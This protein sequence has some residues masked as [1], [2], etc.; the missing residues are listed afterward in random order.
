MKIVAITPDRK[1]NALVPLIIDGLYDN[2]I[3]VIATDPGNGVRSSDVYTDGEVIEHAQDADY[4][5]ALFGK[6]KGPYREGKYHLLDKIKRPEVTAYITDSEWT[7]TSYPDSSFQCQEAKTDPSRHR[8]NPWI[9]EEMYEKCSWYFKRLVFPEDLDRKKIVPCY[10]GA[11]NRYFGPQEEKQYDIFCSF[12][13]LEDGL[14]QP[15]H[16]YCLD[17][18]SQGRNVLINEKFNFDTYLKMIRRSQIGVSA[19][20]AGNCCMRMWEISANKTCCFIQKPFHIVYPNRFVDGESCVYY[21]SMDE[22]KDKM[23][24]YLSRPDECERIGRNAYNHIVKYHTGK[25]RV[26]YMLNV[27]NGHNW[28]TASEFEYNFDKNQ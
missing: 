19:W 26:Q 9:N 8:G 13:Q 22:F 24:F 18:K 1:Y 16:D 14:R 23:Q 12:G 11:C 5:F 2:N 4:I 15:V 27:M 28:R 6:V 3:Q 21:S 20:G 17:L 7:C 10:I 25:K